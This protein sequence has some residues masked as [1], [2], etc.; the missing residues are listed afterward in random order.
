VEPF[1]Q[2]KNK[3]IRGFLFE[4]GGWFC[5]V[6]G[7]ALANGCARYRV[8]DNAR[9]N[10]R[11][12]LF[13]TGNN[14]IGD[15]L[16]IQHGPGMLWAVGP[17]TLRAMTAWQISEDGGG[18]GPGSILAASTRGRK[19]G[20]VWLVGHDLFLWS[21]KGF[22]TGSANTANSVLVG[23]HYE[24]VD[25]SIGCNGTTGIPCAPLGGH[26]GQFHRNRIILNEWDLWYFIRPRMSLG[27][28]VL[29][30]D[31]SNLRNGANQA[32]HNLGICDSP[33]TAANCR[34]GKGGDWIDVFFN[35][36]YTF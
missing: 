25:V 35:W 32:A 18:S 22:L 10:G 8:R 36:R 31:A 2:I 19:K 30:Y 4:Y 15:G 26:L 14:T 16:S 6:D 34:A 11:Q 28:S 12:T 13:D 3:W 29:W 23:Y 9:G 17:Y 24:R 21:P 27:M 1:S 20:R 7:R 33:V 5:N